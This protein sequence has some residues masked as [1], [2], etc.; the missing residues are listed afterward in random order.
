M[1]R[2]FSISQRCGSNVNTALLP[3][4]ILSNFWHVFNTLP[5]Q[6][7]DKF[8]NAFVMA[9]LNCHGGSARFWPVSYTPQA[10]SILG[11]PT[12]NFMKIGLVYLAS[13]CLVPSSTIQWNATS[14]DEFARKWN[15]PVHVF[16]LRHVYASAISSHKLSR[17][18]ASFWT[19]FLSAAVHEFVMAIVTKKLR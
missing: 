11:L 5:S 16:L 1:N 10:E 9:L 8:Q 2:P 18:W 14:W 17:G 6:D 12:D 13:Q 19:F 15:K 7:A 3:I 4:I